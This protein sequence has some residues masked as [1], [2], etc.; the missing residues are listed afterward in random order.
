[1]FF[2]RHK[3]RGSFFK[4][5]MGRLAL[6]VLMPSDITLLLIVLRGLAY[7]AQ[8]SKLTK[9]GLGSPPPRPSRLRRT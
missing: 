4:T 2:P 1:M 5:F 8:P 9:P 6:F 7:G 3:E